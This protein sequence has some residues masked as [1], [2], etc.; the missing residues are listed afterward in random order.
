MGPKAWEAATFKSARKKLEQ[1]SREIVKITDMARFVIYCAPDEP[2]LRLL[3]SPFYHLLA[4]VLL[5]S[6]LYLSDNCATLSGFRLL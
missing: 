6:V 3:E 4:S 1:L 2:K 5:F